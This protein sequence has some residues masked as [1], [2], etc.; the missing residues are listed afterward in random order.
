[1][2]YFSALAFVIASVMVL[3]RRIFNPN[4][5]ITIL[6]SVLLSAFFVNHVNYMT[7]VNFDYGYN[8]TVNILFGKFILNNLMIHTLYFFLYPRYFN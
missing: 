8:L 2:D 4:R 6:F 1:M 7:F 5:F 3:H